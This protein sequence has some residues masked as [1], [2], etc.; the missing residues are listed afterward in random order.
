[1]N[2]L[3]GYWPDVKGIDQ[4]GGGV[5]LAVSI[6]GFFGLTTRAEWIFSHIVFQSLVQR[7]P[8]NPRQKSWLTVAMHWLLTGDQDKIENENRDE[9][10]AILSIQCSK[11][12]N[13]LCNIFLPKLNHY[14]RDD[15]DDHHC[16][17]HHHNLCQLKAWVRDGWGG[18]WI[19]LLPC[20]RCL[21][22]ST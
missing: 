8:R 14:H 13:I 3:D 7:W 21:V 11:K 4:L 16:H 5:K 19:R 15:D 12:E 22:P 2:C 18:L 20:W 6:K 1:M 17:H 9:T 10:S